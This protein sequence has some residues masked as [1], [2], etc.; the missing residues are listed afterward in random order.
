LGDVVWL[1]QRFIVEAV[2]A[3]QIASEVGCSTA[4]VWRALAEAG[5]RRGVHV[6]PGTYPRL[7]D[8]EWLRDRYLVQGARIGEIAAEVGC[9]E[10]AVHHALVRARIP[11]RGVPRIYPQLGDESWL[12]LRYVEQRISVGDIAEELGCDGSTVIAALAAAGIP[13]PRPTRG[14][15]RRFAELGDH[16]WLRRRYLDEGASLRELA[17]EIGCSIR[18]VRKALAEAQVTLRPQGRWVKRSSNAGSDG[19]PS[20]Y[21]V[22]RR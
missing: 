5:L 12:R 10:L 4:T 3:G 2:S 15:P 14:R 11:L 16:D 1:R 8:V 9:R 18:A 7:G 20:S 13:R 21:R 22:R 17:V 6:D 19:A